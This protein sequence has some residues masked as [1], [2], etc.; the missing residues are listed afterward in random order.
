M[1]QSTE[2][3]PEV[4]AHAGTDATESAFHSLWVVTRRFFA[5]A[6]CWHYERGSW[7]YD[8]ICA[9]ILGFIFLPRSWFHDRPQLQLSDLR[10]V[11]GVVE[12]GHS[13]SEHTY[14]IDARLVES[15]MVDKSIPAEKP[16]D[17]LRAI[18]QPRLKRRPTFK[19]FEP[20]RD[21]NNVILGY[22]VVV[23]Q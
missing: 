15:V 18:L 16:E 19:S 1:A 13:R 4:A 9:V 10:H 20:I 6:I 2:I 22:R 21:K 5:N 3:H 14:E 8:I 17:A 23:A 11:Q 7:Q 12:V